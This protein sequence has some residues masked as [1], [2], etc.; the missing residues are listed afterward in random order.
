MVI[1]VQHLA[2]TYVYLWLFKNSANTAH[3]LIKLHF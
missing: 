1:F 3:H 2:K